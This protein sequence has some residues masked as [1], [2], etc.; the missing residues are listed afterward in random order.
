[1]RNLI[2]LLNGDDSDDE[3]EENEEN[4]EEEING[5]HQRRNRR[6]PINYI[7]LQMLQ[8]LHNDRENSSHDELLTNLMRYEKDLKEETREYNAFKEIRRDFFVPEKYKNKAFNDSPLDI[9]ELKTNLSSPHIY[10]KCLLLMDIDP[11]KN[12]SILDIG[13]GTGWFSVLAAHVGGENCSVEG[14]D[15]SQEIINEAYKNLKNVDE[16]LGKRIK[17]K[18]NNA[19]WPTYN[20]CFKQFDRIHVGASIPVENRLQIY[21]LLKPYGKLVSPIAEGLFVVTNDPEQGFLEKS[22]LDV[23]YRMLILPEKIP[24]WIPKLSVHIKYPPII[25]EQIFCMMKIYFLRDSLLSYLPLE[26]IFQILSW[27]YRNP[28]NSYSSTYLNFLKQNE[29]QF[30]KKHNL[31]RSY[32]NFRFENSEESDEDD[33][34][35]NNDSDDE[36]DELH[37]DENVNDELEDEQFLQNHNANLT[38][39]DDESEENM[40]DSDD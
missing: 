14:W 8:Q 28:S 23:R 1:M 20:N 5:E 26:I 39:P 38:H 25:K 6:I 24:I 13:C 18:V 35:D 40:G 16:K 34:D 7:F 37:D 9:E 33:E 30:R 15:L 4:E 36:N 21:N 3:N 19:F 32:Y 31:E 10:P 2:Q 22:H 27:L 29:I 12:Q 17:Y 11:E